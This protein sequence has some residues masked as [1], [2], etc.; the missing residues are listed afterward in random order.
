MQIYNRK[1]IVNAAVANRFWI[2]NWILLVS[3]VSNG[4]CLFVFSQ[5]KQPNRVTDNTSISRMVLVKFYFALNTY[6]RVHTQAQCVRGCAWS[7]PYFSDLV[8]AGDQ[9]WQA[10]LLHSERRFPENISEL[11]FRGKRLISLGPGTLTKQV[12]A[13]VQERSIK[14]N[15]YL[16][17][18]NKNSHCL[19]NV[20]SL[21]CAGSSDRS[22]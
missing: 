17:R 19:E 5:R 6:I 10:R 15:C 11:H 20:S 9:E 3:K 4:A 18:S 13:G 12:C 2:T 1:Q 22:L 16:I 14:S 8:G 7:V 21:R